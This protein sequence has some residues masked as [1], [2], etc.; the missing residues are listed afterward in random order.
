[1]E[2]I[3]L[4]MP[5]YGPPQPEAAR[6]FWKDAIDPDGPHAHYRVERNDLGNSLLG[7]TFNIHW[8][9]ALNMQLDGHNVTRFA[10]LHNDIGPEKFWLDKLLDDLDDTGSDV[11]AACVSMKDNRMLVSTAVDAD[12]DTPGMPWGVKTR[13]RAS[14][15]PALPPVFG[16]EDLG[17]P[18]GRLLLNTGCWVADFTKPWRHA[19]AG[20][21][22]LAC[23]FEVKSRILLNEQGRYQAVTLSEDWNFSR[24]VQ[25]EGGKVM[26][27]RRLQVAHYGRSA[28]VTWGSRQRSQ[29]PVTV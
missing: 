13:L 9:N 22:T 1:L 17:E 2:V 5:C 23:C 29:T 12:P 18:A 27:S 16:S 11:V 6:A 21:G 24:M 3:Y 14:D 20:D 7:E 15:L 10:M 28:W 4:C 25:A 26:A 19:V 8:A